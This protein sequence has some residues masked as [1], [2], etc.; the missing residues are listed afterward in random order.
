MKSLSA[1]DLTATVQHCNNDTIPRRAVVLMPQV[2]PPGGFTTELRQT[3]Q[4]RFATAALVA[5]FASGLPS[6]APESFLDLYRPCAA[7]FTPL[8]ERS[9]GTNPKEIFFFFFKALFILTVI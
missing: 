7:Y 5:S 2:T 1:S 3:C 6:F 8:F 4:I 9:R